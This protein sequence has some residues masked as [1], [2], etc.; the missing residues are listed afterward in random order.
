MMDGSVLAD[1][2]M[3]PI[4]ISPA[5]ARHVS[6][7]VLSFKSRATMARTLEA[8]AASGLMDG[9]GEFFIHFNAM[10]DEDRW[11][12]ESARVRYEGTEENFGIYG[13]FRAIVERARKPFVLILEN[14]II[15]LP[16]AGVV[17]CIARCVHDMQTH[18][19][20]VFSLRSRSQP[21]EGEPHA[22]Y[23]RTF[24]V[25]EPIVA[26]LAAD[27]TSLVARAWMSIRHLGIDRFRGASIF[28]EKH[29]DDVQPH[30]VKKL[31][32]G[33]YLTDSRFRNW[34]NQ[35]VLVERDFFLDVV[36][37]RVDEHPDPRLVNGYQDI[38]RALNCRWWRLR[39]QSMGHAA[40]GVYTHSRLDR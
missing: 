24:G 25:K 13:G 16:G 8:H 1:T 20:K 31:P 19:I 11:M 21:G 15:P 36:C 17:E 30:A 18:S 23:V 4:A 39:E 26:G 27:E 37:K 3:A 22:K 29:P 2:A 40:E 33:N 14:D 10:D 38:E 5:L 7:G 34:S 28:A 35:S 12:A 6:V 32:S 9:V